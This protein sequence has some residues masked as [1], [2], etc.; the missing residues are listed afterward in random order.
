MPTESSE[1]AAG[2]NGTATPSPE[3]S[4]AANGSRIERAERIVDNISQGATGF[5][6]RLGQGVGRFFSRARDEV[7][8]IWDD[9]QSV[10][11]GEPAQP[12]ADGNGASA[13]DGA[14]ERG[15]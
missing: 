3:S 8:S 15:S 10:R 2:A 11:R 9:A 6:S 12:P 13:S 14:K 1:P 4:A 7:R 5:A